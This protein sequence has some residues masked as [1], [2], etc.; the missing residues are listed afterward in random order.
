VFFTGGPTS[1]VNLYKSY[2]NTGSVDLYG[3]KLK[4]L[5]DNRVTV[6]ATADAIGQSAIIEGFDENYQTTVTIL[7]TTMDITLLKPGLLIGFN[8]FGTFVDQ[9]LAQIVRVEYTPA[10]AKLTLGILPK[11]LHPE[12]EKITRGLIAQQTLANPTAPS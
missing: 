10:E 2:A 6:A 7:D 8:G 3:P 1:G 11:R 9:I 5:S 4:R 12:F